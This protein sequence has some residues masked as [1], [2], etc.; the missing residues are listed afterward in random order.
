MTIIKQVQMYFTCKSNFVRNSNS[1]KTRLQVETNLLQI[2][3]DQN[4]CL[5]KGSQVVD[6]CSKSVIEQEIKVVGF[7]E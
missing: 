5:E 6:T 2:S 7:S 1:S 3:I 4:L